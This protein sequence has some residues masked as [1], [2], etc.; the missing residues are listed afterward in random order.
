MAGGGNAGEG[1]LEGIVVEGDFAAA[2]STDKVVM[3]LLEV[4]AELD[5]AIGKLV[6]GADIQEEAGGAIE[7]DAVHGGE[8]WDAA[9]IAAM[10]AA[11]LMEC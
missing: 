2:L 3:V 8:V 5:G 10:A 11:G 9:Q 7:G 6:G 1:L 4:V